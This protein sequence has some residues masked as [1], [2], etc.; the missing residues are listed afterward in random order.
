LSPWA[1]ALL[2]SV[3]VATIGSTTYGCSGYSDDE[4]VERCQAE[5]Q[6]K[7]SEFDD[8]SY[9]SC[10]SCFEDCGDSCAADDTSPERYSCPN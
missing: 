3:A 9:S 10:L 4:A 5:Q 1:R 2:A 6:A 7:A 8:Q